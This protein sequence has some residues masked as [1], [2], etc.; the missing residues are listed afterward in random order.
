MLG[1]ARVVIGTGTSDRKGRPELVLDGLGTPAAAALRSELLHR[2]PATPA[3]PVAV[4]PQEVTLAALNPHWL[5]SAPFTL[6]G[7]I[8]GLAL[9]GIGWRVVSEGH[10][11]VRRLRP[12]RT[13]TDQLGR[14]PVILDVGVVTAAILAFVALASTV[15]YVLA[16]WNFRLTRHLGGTLHVSRGLVTSR[17]TSIERRRLRGAEVSEPLL[18]RLVGGARCIAIATGLRV[19]RGAE[20]GGEILLPP[21]PRDVAEQVA[22]D[23]IDTMLP[24]AAA[25]NRHPRAALRRRLGRAV[26]GTAA[27]A[28]LAAATVVFAGWPLWLLLVPGALLLAAVPL[29]LDRFRSLGHA[30]ADGYLITRYG[31][32]VRRRSAVATSGIIGWNL[33]STF[34]QRRLGLVSLHATTAAGRQGYPIADLAPAVAV[35]L[36]DETVPGLLSGFLIPAVPR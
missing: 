26:L 30:L 14:W 23:V 24:F 28:A 5:R 4:V 15:G 31:S 13:I 35:R 29:G 36:A 16:F 25:L 6:S 7:A 18:L 34:F 1:L 21:A 33:R 11:N 19:G 10:V 12:V 20:R 8:T 32:L 22:G 27:A 3:V 17:A 2:G 9:L